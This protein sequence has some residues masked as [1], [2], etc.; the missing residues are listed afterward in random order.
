MTINTNYIT[1]LNAKNYSKNT[2]RD[3]IKYT[4]EA[5]D[6]I[7]KSEDKIEYMDLLNWYSTFKDMSVNS[8]NSR[9]SAVRNYFSFLVEFGMIDQNPCDKLKRR[10]VRE[11]DVKQ[12]PYVEAH[13]LRD[14]VNAS[15]NKRDK[16]IVL[17]FATTGL[18]V[19]EL[20]GLTLD[21]WYNMKGEDGRELKIIGKGNKC[22]YVYIA[23]EVKRAIDSYLASNPK[24]SE[25]CN[26]LFVSWQGNHIA[27]N[28]LNNT[29]KRIA[30]DANVPFW[31]DMSNHVLRAAFATT[32]NEQGVPLT[33]IQKSL[34]HSSLRTTAIYIKQTQHNVNAAMQDVAF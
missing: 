31:K 25:G 10:K 19:S 34:G 24:R 27:P 23:D 9:I 8:Q 2:I 20:T 17:L 1:Y 7:G 22:R 33:T 29:I 16:A 12:K 14:M 18:R 6:Y 11:G 4:Q 26:C 5:L 21:D 13:Y 3:Y 30:K 15:K 28:N 32:K